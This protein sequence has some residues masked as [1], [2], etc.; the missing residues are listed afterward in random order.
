MTPKDNKS[1]PTDPQSVAWLG[2]TSAAWAHRIGNT[3]GIVPVY[4]S[5]IK[6]NPGDKEQLFEYLDRIERE[7]REVLGISQEL[8]D[9]SRLSVGSGVGPI[10]INSVIQ[11]T[12]EKHY[13]NRENARKFRLELASDLPD[14][15]ADE[16]LLGEVIRNLVDNSLRAVSGR[17]DG[18]VE[19]SSRYMDDKISIDVTDNG[20][21]IPASLAAKLFQE[22]VSRGQHSEGVGLGLLISRVLVNSWG[23]Q[24]SLV[25]SETTGTTIRV[26]LTPWETPISVSATRRAL[27]V[28]DNSNW[29]ELIKR[30]L[31]ERELAV[32]VAA[33][34]PDAMNLIEDN[35]YDLALLDM[36]LEDFNA[37][38]VTGLN[39]AR[40]LRERN[41]E[42]LIVMLTAYAATSIV[43]DAFRAGVDEFLDKSSFSEAEISRVLDKVAARREIERES[44]RQSQLNKLMYEV[45]S[46]ISHELRAPLLTIQR[47]AEALGLG[48]LGLLNS[49]QSE[50]VATIQSAVQ[51]ELVLLNAHLDLNR[52]ERGAERLEYQE[53]DLAALV[54][55]EILAHQVEADRKGVK[56]KA[57]LPKKKAIVK[58]DV[59]RFRVALNP[60]MDNAIKFSPEKGEVLVTL[61]L[62]ASYVEAR[63]SDRGPGIKPSELD[64]LL[65]WRTFEAA[66][67][68]QRIRSSGLGLS[69]A[70]RMIELHDGKLWVESDG[71]SGTIVGFRLPARE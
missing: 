52:I 13:Q 40:L 3:L 34:L 12:F 5:Y 48:A 1:E 59:N 50:A 67:F 55:E 36:R 68:T 35:E 31:V 22:P 69:M 44:I 10:D 37:S 20:E 19:I 2:V 6:D 62:S 45:L 46:M 47:N 26:S 7:V 60:L 27:V 56:L 32:D 21:G 15:K 41:P 63:V 39:V 29:S 23:G 14:A 58:I 33:S 49:E 71:K 65:N 18:F 54:R 24:L 30:L 4:I 25:R 11:E 8:R 53:Y 17:N 43:R 64:Q 70:K 28:E 38:D 61:S 51:R 9:F 42:T 57:H 66:D 16:Q